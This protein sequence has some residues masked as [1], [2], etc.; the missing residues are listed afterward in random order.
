MSRIALEKCFF[1]SEDW[2]S[3]GGGL[4]SVIIST[5]MGGNFAN[6]AWPCASS[7]RVMPNDQISALQS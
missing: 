2:S 5:F 6:G 1:E 3:V 7:N 4:F